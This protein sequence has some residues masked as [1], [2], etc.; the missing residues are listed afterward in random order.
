METV[1]ARLKKI[2]LEKGIPLE[3]VHKKTK[4]HPDI[5]KSIEDDSFAGLNPVYIKGFLKIYCKFLGVN[6]EDFIMGYRPVKTNLRPVQDKDNRRALLEPLAVNKYFLSPKII[7]L[8]VSV[9]GLI[10]L[11]IALSGLVKFIKGK[12]QAWPKEV[13]RPRIQAPVVKKIKKEKTAVVKPKPRTA[14][15]VRSVI[16]PQSYDVPLASDNEFGL[17]ISIYALEDCWVQA[18]VDGKTLFQNILKS[19]RDE[20]WKAK[21]KAELVLGSAGGIKLEVNGKVIPSLG[22]RGQV[23]KDIV[24]TKEGLR[25]GK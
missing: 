19:G 2:R 22:R 14:A 20:T 10:L 24:I 7:S 15:P 4:I 13:R 1:G 5:L 23:L 25:V 11:V 12:I 9:I 21:E 6:P 3:E 17:R 8:I 16:S 18:K